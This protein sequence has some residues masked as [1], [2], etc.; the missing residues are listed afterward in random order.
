M[1][2]SIFN[3]FQGKQ[4]KYSKHGIQQIIF[5]ANLSEI[6]HAATGSSWDTSKL[7]NEINKYFNHSSLFKFDTALLSIRSKNAKPINKRKKRKI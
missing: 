7:F 3:K 1:V 6:S 4:R 2:G 5:T